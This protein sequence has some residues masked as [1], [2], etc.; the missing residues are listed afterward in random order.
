MNKD[1]Q[2][3]FPQ[4]MKSGL[5]EAERLR[6]RINDLENELERQKN[7]FSRKSSTKPMSN[8]PELGRMRTLIQQLED[9]IR[10]LKRQL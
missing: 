7:A 9:E 5:S 4:S 8:D 6:A 2:T 1:M 10:D 3:S